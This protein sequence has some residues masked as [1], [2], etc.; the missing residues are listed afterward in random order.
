M[1]RRMSAD[2][3]EL[4]PDHRCLRIIAWDL[5]SDRYWARVLITCGNWPVEVDQDAGVRNRVGAWDKHARERLC[6]AA[7]DVEVSASLVELGSA[8]ATGAVQ[9]N[10][11]NTE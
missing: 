4:T 5:A 1:N 7:R 8:S 2:R 9:G 3:Q 10:V 11:L 6:P